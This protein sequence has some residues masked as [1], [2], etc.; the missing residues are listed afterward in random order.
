MSET[1]PLPHDPIA[2]LIPVFRDQEG[3]ETTLASLVVPLGSWVVVVDD[4]SP[5]PVTIPEG[6]PYPVQLIRQPQNTGITGALNTGLQAILETDAA[7]VA[8][9]DAGD[10]ARSDRL[11]RQ[12]ALLRAQPRTAVVGSWIAAGPTGST[13]HYWVRYPEAPEAIRRELHLRNCIAHPSA[14]IRASVFREVGLYAEGYPAAEDY[15]LFFRI[16]GRYDLANIPEPLTRYHFSPGGI[17]SQ[18]RRKQIAS[19]LA[20]QR[21]YFRPTEVRAYLGLLRTMGHYL[22][23]YRALVGL[24]TRLWRSRGDGDREDALTVMAPASAGRSGGPLVSIVLPTYNRA[25]LLEDVVANIQR[26]TL[27][28]WELI[29]VDDGSTDHT[30]QVLERIAAAEP[31]VRPVRHAHNQRLPAALNTGFREARGRFLT[32]TSDDNAYDP[33][34]LETLWQHLERNPDAGLAYAGYRVMDPDGTL[35]KV[36][37]ARPPQQLVV[38]NVVGACFLYRR[39]VLDAVGPYAEDLFLS[40][41]YDY[42]LRTAAHFG[43][44]P[45]NRPLYSYTLTPGSLRERRREVMDATVRALERNLAAVPYAVGP[46]R[47]LASLNLFRLE[48][49][50]GRWPRAWQRLAAAVTGRTATPVPGAEPKR[51]GTA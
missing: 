26:Q 42:W 33:D 35:R 34:A 40:E 21:K 24:K 51:E 29:L 1:T 30:A 6:L 37:D 9:I 49:R 8:R 16:A 46:Y 28:D 13:R 14:M 39:E 43:L 5:E 38:R 48:A 27:T 23:P 32:W 17:S 19:T 22:L 12:R 25:D 31:R 4:A 11:E 41:D 15:E 50:L 3:L 7:Y 18:R 20:V 10:T 44:V 45:V 36:V 47:R 2:V